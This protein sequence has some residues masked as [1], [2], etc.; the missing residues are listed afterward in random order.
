MLIF[1]AF[2]LFLLGLAGS[3]YIKR[4]QFYRRNSNGLEVFSS[5]STMLATKLYEK[6][7]RVMSLLSI[8][9]SII[10]VLYYWNSQLPAHESQRTL[11]SNTPS[12]HKKHHAHPE[13]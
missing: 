11:D 1:L 13:G 6:M 3:H 9:A 2:C 8:V 5:Y 7:V 12:S 10:C 4:R